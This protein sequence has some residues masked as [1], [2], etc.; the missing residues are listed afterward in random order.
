MEFGRR[1][2]E[3][4]VVEGV[5]LDIGS[6]HAAKADDECLASRL[7]GVEYRVTAGALKVARPRGHILVDALQVQYLH[8]IVNKLFCNEIE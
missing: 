3:P 4:Q 5:D 2:G 1:V 8:D 6:R 7:S